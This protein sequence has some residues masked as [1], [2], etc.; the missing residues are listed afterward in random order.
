MEI[1]VFPIQMPREPKL[2]LPKIGQGQ[3]RVMIY[4]NYLIL[5]T[6][7]QHIKFRGN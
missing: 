2:T 6:L 5:E 7:M 3:P 4:T 1:P